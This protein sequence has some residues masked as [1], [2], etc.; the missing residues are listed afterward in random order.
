M[1]LKKI[2][3]FLCCLLILS[4]CTNSN[5]QSQKRPDKNQ[6][7]ETSGKS[8]ANNRNNNNDK[9]SD[10][11][12]MFYNVENLF[13]TYDDPHKNDNE[14]LPGGAMRWTPGRYRLHLR[15]TAQV[16]SAVG[17]WGT[18]AVCGLCEVESDTVLTHLLNRTPL[19]E[20]HYSYCMT[21][22]SDARGINNA[23]LYQRDKFRYLGHSSE[24]I[25]F[26]DKNRRS[27]DILHVWGEVINGERLDIFV[28][29]FP[30]RS[31]GEKESEQRRMDAAGCLRRLCDSVFEMNGDANIIV[32]GDFNDNPRDKS[33]RILTESAVKA[34]YSL[35]NLF[36]DPG[37]LNFGGSHKFQGEWSQLDQM[38][39]SRNW[40]RYLREGSPQIFVRSFLLTP[41]DSRGEQSPFRKYAGRFYKGG[42][43]DH[44][45]V[46][47]DFLLPLSPEK[48]E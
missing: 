3:P 27:R 2:T 42:Y 7:L 48:S 24:R 47:A 11:R 9:E 37:R 20:Q 46:F 13:D 40:N 44:L 35:I 28:C 29:H 32:M 12:V 43:S 14:F 10:F 16:I 17:E 8:P 26:T 4:G 36:G 1:P 33:I 41:R 25:P 5:A 30:S 22:G 23:L 19:R 6:Q 21:A 15:R 18:P 39:I 31:G 45:P 38:M 34:E